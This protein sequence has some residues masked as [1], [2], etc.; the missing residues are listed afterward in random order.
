MKIKSSQQNKWI[1]ELIIRTMAPIQ[2]LR[3]KAI[4]KKIKD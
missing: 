4:I 3:F 1:M 2:I